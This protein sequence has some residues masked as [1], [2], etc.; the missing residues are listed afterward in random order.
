MM[1]F[2]RGRGPA[3][4]LGHAREPHRLRQSSSAG[5]KLLLTPDENLRKLKEEPLQ[6]VVGSD[7]KDMSQVLGIREAKA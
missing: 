3:P 6:Y 2:Q 5:R 4:R 7:D 1:V